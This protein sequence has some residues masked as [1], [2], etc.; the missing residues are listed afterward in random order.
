LLSDDSELGKYNR[1]VSRQQLGKHVP[2]ARQQIPNNATVGLQQRNSCFLRGPCRDVKSETRFGA[3][4]VDCQF[5]SVGESVK[6][7][8]EQEAEE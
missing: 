5:T 1:P 7:G 3:E 8:L 2:V 4:F 6:G